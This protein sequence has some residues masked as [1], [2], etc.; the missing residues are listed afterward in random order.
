M[1]RKGFLAVTLRDGP[2]RNFENL[3]VYKGILGME[4]LLLYKGILAMTGRGSP[5]RQSRRDRRRKTLRARSRKVAG[6]IHSL[7]SRER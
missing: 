2:A 6:S 5:G 1:V 3:L 4:N 7:A